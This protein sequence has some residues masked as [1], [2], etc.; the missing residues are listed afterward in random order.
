MAPAVHLARGATLQGVASRDLNRSRALEPVRIFDTYSE[1]IESPDVDAVYVSLTN[2]Q[3]CHWVVE[4]VSAGKHVLCE[5]PLGLDAH[6]VATMRDAARRA[7]RAIVE[8]VWVR[9]H[10]R[11]RRFVDLVRSGVLGEEV[12]LESSFMFISDMTGNYRLHPDMGGGALLD[13]GC[14][15]VHTWLAAF[16]STIDIR[17]RDVERVIG[18]TGVDLTTRAQALLG[19]SASGDLA[20]SFIEGPRQTLMA[21]GS[22][23]EVTMLDGEAFTSWREES[24]LRIGDSIETFPETDAFVLMVEQVSRQFAGEENPLFAFDESYRTAQVLDHI[25][26]TVRT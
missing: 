2:S 18:P 10:P 25:A 5:K 17:I 6:E 20:C 14:Y 12:R 24:S 9:W 15:Q 13:V 23:A 8:A 22:S 21:Q 1:L 7:D 26:H 19:E 11:H 16:G 4:A 3:H